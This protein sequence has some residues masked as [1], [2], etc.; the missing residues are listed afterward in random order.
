[1]SAETSIL[2]DQLAAAIADHTA[3]RVPLSIEPWSTK[4]I[5]ACYKVSESHVL[6]RW[7]SRTDFPK[8]CRLPSDG[9]RSGRPRWKATEVIAWAERFKDKN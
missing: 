7:A 8:A 9:G 6:Q 4:E 5:A 2:L 1:M 3:P